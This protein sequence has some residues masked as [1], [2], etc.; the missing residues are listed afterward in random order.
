M[1]NACGNIIEKHL[2]GVKSAY[3]VVVF[4]KNAYRSSFR[5]QGGKSLK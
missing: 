2:K 1:K 4:V 5:E 3:I